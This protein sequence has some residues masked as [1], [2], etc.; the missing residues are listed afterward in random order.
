MQKKGGGERK[1]RFLIELDFDF[2]P[3]A[4]YLS[5]IQFFFFFF[6]QIQRTMS[7]PRFESIILELILRNKKDCIFFFFCALYFTC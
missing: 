6:S 5:A 1:K 3:I 2:A 7:L 4:F